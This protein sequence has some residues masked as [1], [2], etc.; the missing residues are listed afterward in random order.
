MEKIDALGRTRQADLVEEYR[1]KAGEA[2]KGGKFARAQAFLEA[3]VAK[4]PGVDAARPLRAQLALC[5]QLVAAHHIALKE[6]IEQLTDPAATPGDIPTRPK[7]EENPLFIIEE[8]AVPELDFGLPAALLR[9]RLEARGQR[10]AR[11]LQVGFEDLST[12][13]LAGHTVLL[14]QTIGPAMKV[15]IAQGVDL[16]TRITLVEESVASPALTE[17]ERAGARRQLTLLSPEEF[18]AR[19]A[20][21]LGAAIVLLADGTDLPEGIEHAA[22]LDQFDACAVDELGGLRP[23]EDTARR[24]RQVI[25][26]QPDFY[27][28]HLV[29]AQAL[30]E[31][32]QQEGVTQQLRDAFVCWYQEARGLFVRS[33]WLLRAYARFLAVDNRVLEAA[34]IWSDVFH[35]EPGDVEAGLACAGAL[36]RIGDLEEAEFVLT[37]LLAHAPTCA[38]AYELRAGLLDELG[39]PGAELMTRIAA[40]LRA[41]YAS[42]AGT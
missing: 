12:L 5:R 40:Q 15:V 25:D 31:R 21:S 19:G 35:E 20:A 7:P 39:V 11:V 2:L 16:N 6:N 36:A 37:T 30:V 22:L 8:R 24:A 4:T 29:Y 28:A 14:Q 13:L 3:C 42:S 32:M 33:S 26:A 38:R 1:Q 18:W 27:A 9:Q 34:A 10:T 17:G 23:P 41:S